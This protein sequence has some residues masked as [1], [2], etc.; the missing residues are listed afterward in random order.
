MEKYSGFK[1]HEPGLRIAFDFVDVKRELSTVKE[2]LR[3]LGVGVE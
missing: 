1:A 3:A 2:Q